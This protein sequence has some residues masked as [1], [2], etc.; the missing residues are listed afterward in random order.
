MTCQAFVYL[1]F[2][3]LARRFYLGSHAGSEEDNY[4]CSSKVMLRAYKKRHE[5]FRRR[6]IKRCSKQEQYVWEQYFLNM[7]KDSELFYRNKKYYNIKRIATGGDTTKNLP[8]RDEVIKR[9]YG[10][11]HSNA[12]KTAIK[13]K[14][15]EQKLLHRQR[16]H[17][18]LMATLLDPSYANYQDKPYH[19][20]VNGKFYKTYKNKKQ[21]ATENCCCLGE[22]A[23]H[24]KRQHW[25]IKQKR[26]HPFNV[27]DILTFEFVLESS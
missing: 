18:S 14:S 24:F 6:I 4:I 1:W 9:R 11:H 7:I 5:S 12:V 27:G 17:K 26:K 8:N 3:S 22:F 2:D 10:M 13:N 21:F 20:F 19:V 23:K 25:Q 15:N 16:H